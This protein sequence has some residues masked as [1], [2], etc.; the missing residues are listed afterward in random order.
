MAPVSVCCCPARKFLTCLHLLCSDTCPVWRAAAVQWSR[1]NLG[2]SVTAVRDF[3]VERISTSAARYFAQHLPDQEALPAVHPDMWAAN[4]LQ[5]LVPEMIGPQ[6]EHGVITH[7]VARAWIAAQDDE[8]TLYTTSTPPRLHYSGE[9]LA[10]VLHNLP[11]G[12]VIQDLVIDL[13]NVLFY[14][15]RGTP[16]HK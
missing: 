7:E 10:A 2:I 14:T 15:V 8:A 9:D 4:R 5:P 1:T 16:Y 6:P 11:G 3:G 13:G 12:V